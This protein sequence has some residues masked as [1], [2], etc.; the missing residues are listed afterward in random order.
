[1][2]HR[3]VRS[4]IMSSPRV[5]S[6]SLAVSVVTLGLVAC[7]TSP[8]PVASPGPTPSVTTTTTVVVTPP[9]VASTASSN[10]SAQPKPEVV[11]ADTPSGDDA[12]RDAELTA[13]AAGIFEAFANT[14]PKLT[15]DGKKVVFKSNRD[16][17]PQLYVSEVAKPEAAPVRVVSTKQR[18][19]DFLIAPDGL[20]IIFL[21]DQG[22][23]EN[24]SIFK[25]GL[26][27]GAVTELTKGETL[28]RDRPVVPLGAKGTMFYSARANSEKNARI[29][30]QPV[31]GGAAK[32]LY[33]DPGSSFLVDVSND[34]KWGLLLRL[35]SLSDSKVVLVDLT[36]GTAKT[37][38]PSEGKSEYV[39]QA[40][41]SADASTIYLSTDG[42]A[43]QALVLAFD[44]KT[45]AEKARYVEKKPATANIVDIV[46]GR[47]S[48]DRIALFLDAGNHAELRLLDGK[49]LKAGPAVTMPLGSGGSLDILDDGSQATVHWSTPDAPND[50]FAIDTKTGKVKPLRKEVRPTLAKL[51][52]LKAS[53]AEVTSFDGTKIPVNLYLPDPMPKGK[54][55]PAMVIVHGG[56]A[57]SYEIR[58][59]SLNRFY[60]AHGFAI[61]EPNIRGSTGFGRKYEQAD[62]G[63]KRLD[64]V[65]DVEELG[66]WAQKQPWVDADRLV[67][68]GGSYGGY[69]T[70]MGVTRH[71]TLW[72]A[73]V[74]L[75]GIY[76]WKAFM[77]TTSGIIRDVFQKEIGAESDAAFLDSISP[78]SQIDQVVAPLFVYAGQNDPRVPRS[79]SDAIVKNLRSRKI[80][81]EYM[82]AADE[83]HSLDR[84][85]N[86]TAFLARSHRFL[87][88]KLKLTAV[89]A[90]K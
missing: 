57:S 75:F 34:G 41:F 10:A 64:A 29:Y 35:S 30:S 73:G 71:P 60:S 49:T 83:G 14:M 79:E 11:E 53:I 22:A 15:P 85:E 9:P 45:L 66:K 69:M 68:L 37:I 59:S 21:S 82:V 24:W 12:K 84:K 16:G 47:K 72:K 51:P 86:V 38:H 80:P 32:L 19:G 23:D 40:V 1:M 8:A 6:T 4:E 90:S 89:V 18:I 5:R 81:V 63:T 52:K 13:D 62:D 26:D 78:E 55:L 3:V 61:I 77:K 48:G 56:P 2:P 54:K 20:S 67:L 7:G 50:L 25:V 44:A 74:D 31:D 33:T 28:H 88:N 87:E 42:G 27:G 70:L 17:I 65:R 58:W 36:A 46:V 39:K 43:E 76:S